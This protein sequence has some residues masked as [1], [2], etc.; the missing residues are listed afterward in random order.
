MLILVNIMQAQKQYAKQF[1]DKIRVVKLGNL[2][3]AFPVWMSKVKPGIFPHRLLNST[4]A[5]Y[6]AMHF[7]GM[8]KSPKN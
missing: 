7:Q 3:T 8:H 6:R 1:Q 4:R 5:K 2:P